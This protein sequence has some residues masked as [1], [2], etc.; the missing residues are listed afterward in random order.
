ME[1]AEM[2]LGAIDLSVVRFFQNP[3]DMK[4]VSV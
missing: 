1:D 4:V 2:I 3:K